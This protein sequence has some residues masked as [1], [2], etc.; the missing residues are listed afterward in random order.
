MTGRV[1]AQ[2]HGV[3]RKRRD[4]PAVFLGFSV[5]AVSCLNPVAQLVKIAAAYVTALDVAASR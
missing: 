5:P 1:Q 4:C 3:K 2:G